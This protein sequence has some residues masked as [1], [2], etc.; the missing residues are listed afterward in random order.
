VKPQPLIPT[1]PRIVRS[2]FVLLGAAALLLSTGV[3]SA[4]GLTL[5]NP[6][7]NITL[8]DAGYSD[9][10]LDN[11]PGFEGR[12]YLSGE[13]GAAVGYQVA[14]HPVTTPQWLE[15]YFS[16]PDW[17]NNSTFTVVTPL[18]QTGLNADN[19]PIA[20][21]VIANGELQITLR[22]EMLDT[23][24]G[25]PMGITPA[26]SASSSNAINSSRY[27]LKQTATIK[28]ISGVAVSGLQFFQFVHGLHSQRGVY[29]DRAYPGTLGDF[30]YDVTLAGVDPYSVGTNSSSVGLEDFL[31]FHANVTPS[32]F[33]IGYYGIEGNGIDDHWMGK[34]S[35]GVH[36]SIE[37]N[38]QQPPYNTR[39]GTD[40][41]APPQRWV[42]GA[43]RWNLGSLAADQSVSLDI[44]LSLRTGT[45]VVPGTNSTGSCN[46]GSSVPG[47]E[48]YEFDDVTTPGSCFGEYS[49]ADANEISVRIAQGEFD[50]FTFLQPGGLQQLW[51]LQFS[52]TYTGAVHLTFGYDATVL[53]P[54]LDPTG[55]AIYQFDGAAWQK[56]ATTVGTASHTLMVTATNLSTFALGVDNGVAYTVNVSESPTGAGII[57]GG[58][59]YADG[60]LATLVV[61]ANAGY[62][63]TNWT[64]GATVVSASP[65]YSFTV[66]A[67]RTL[68]ANF[69]S[70]GA[71][72]AIT[73]SASPPEGG[74]T[75]GD[76]AY[77]MESA[78]TVIAQANT[79]YKFS[80]WLVNGTQVSTSRTNTFTVTGDR[81]LVAKFKPVYSV[82]VSAD[83]SN[84]GSVEADSSTYEPSEVAHLKARP[85]SAY[86]FINW[87][88]N[89]AQVSTETNF[90]FTVTGNRMLV[91]H[92]ALGRMINASAYPGL[93]GTVTGG[94]VYQ[95]GNPVALVAA[96]NPGYV[97]V[98]WTENG[99]T[100]S[101]SETYTF[102][103]SASRTLV[104]NFA[105]G[106]PGLTVNVSASPADGGTVSGGGTFTNGATATVIASLNAGYAFANWTEAGAEVSTSAS[107]TF[108][109]TSSRTLV[110]NFTASGTTV[111]ITAGAV[112][113][114]GGTVAGNGTYTNGDW[115]SLYATPEPGYAFLNWTDHGT[116]VS[117]WTYYSFT[118]E[119]N[120]TLAANFAPI[121]SITTSAASTNGTTG[122][123]GDFPVGA[124]VGVVASPKAGFVF[125]NWTESGVPVS[126]N[127]NYVFTVD[128]NRTLVANFSA[129]L[130]STTFDFDTATPA[131]TYLQT[132]PFTQTVAGLDAQFSSASDPAFSVQSDASNY[133]VMPKFSGNYLH[134][135]A[136]G[137][138]LMIHFSKSLT[139]IELT[140]ATSDWQDLITPTP[141]KLEAFVNSTNTPAGST[142]G[143][144]SIN[145]ADTAPASG[146]LSLQS[147][148][149]FNLVRISLPPAGP[150]SATDF[151]VDN[152]TVTTIPALNMH[153]VGGS[154]IIS[155]P[156][157]DA[158]V[159]QRSTN[160]AVPTWINV[161][162]GIS[163][164]GGQK[165]FTES[166]PAVTGFFR[167]VRP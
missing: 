117:S 130:T 101:T 69:V 42:S 107:Y 104:A 100:A 12:E 121:G 136:S 20:Q 84:G 59:T 92:F 102:T 30:R 47:G 86:C 22:Q 51:K 58:G 72:K 44:I 5:A 55:L 153:L 15:K 71:N 61:T 60:T 142:T 159:L 87:T 109:V 124:K 85:N 127:A 148:T 120:R 163:V 76:G 99:I 43:Q 82:S 45:Q 3:A 33:E 66:H 17:T 160:L 32:G 115:V 52:G 73:T 108:T 95:N 112:P 35:E 78:A 40:N 132:T 1:L 126:S 152:I 98:D 97:F 67:D 48:D 11:T 111:L 114:A 167:L 91:G 75:S 164:V 133:W 24:V 31:G 36:L 141:I 140:F 18:T 54:G 143:T 19:L 146:R 83:P 25:T 68:V 134:S 93:G 46:G 26:S 74:T 157:T 9:F 158:Y 77:P 4:Q 62:V 144:G 161:T 8:T 151:L 28:N 165:L 94:G 90:S 89:G 166:P 118:A 56:L 149:P 106:N 110:A 2:L 125:V 129:D 65:G 41:F 37:D 16:F 27:V 14:G 155:W 122:G 63:F 29:D 162:N 6:Q 64:E 10:L 139:S 113:V 34:P 156:V 128:A 131:L 105:A 138:D 123:D 119:T 38:W 145:T 137:S 81:A 49:K 135:D 23:I 50:T 154:A 70:V 39:I 80:K 57:T 7:W 88:Q 103:C 147:A 21:S 13:W 96:A 116:P 150:L 53:P 79:G